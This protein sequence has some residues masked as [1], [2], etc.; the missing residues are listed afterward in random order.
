VTENG[1]VTT[2][3]RYDGAD[4][5][6]AV[7][8]A[9]TFGAGNTCTNGLGRSFTYD[10]L[11]RLGS[12]T[13]PESGVIQYTQYDGNGNLTGKTDARSVAASMTYDQLNRIR[14]KS[15]NDGVTP[16]VTYCYDGTVAGANQS[17]V[18][19]SVPNGKGRLTQVYSS[20][21][22]ATYPAFDGMGRVLLSSQQTP[23]GTG[24][25]LNFG[26]SAASPGYAYNLAGQLT[27]VT[28][29]SGRQVKY[30]YDAAGRTAHVKNPAASSYA[31]LSLFNANLGQYAYAAFGGIQQMNL[32]NSTSENTTWDPVRLQPTQIQVAPSL[33]TLNYY[34]CPNNGAS[35]STN[36]GNVLSQVIART[37]WS[38]TQNYTYTDGF[39]RLNSA[40]EW[41]TGSN[42]PSLNWSQTYQYDN[43]GNRAVSGYLPNASL[44]PQ[45]LSQYTGNRY[46]GSGAGYDAAG[47]LTAL[48]NQT[49]TYDAENR[50]TSSTQLGIGAIQ[51]AYD[52]DG[53]RVQK[54]FDTAATTYVYDA[55]GQLAAEYGTPTDTGTNYLNVDALGSTRVSNGSSLRNYDYFPFGEDIQQ[56][57]GGRNLSYPT[58]TY[59]TGTPDLQAMKFT[60]QLRDA[61]TGLDYFGARYFSGAQGR[62][63]SADPEGRGGKVPDPQSWN[64]YSYARNNPLL[65]T[66]PTG[67]TYQIC[68]KDDNGKDQCSSVSDE[69]F[70]QLQKNPGSGISLSNGDINAFVNGEWT[71]AGTYWQTDV[72]LPAGVGMALHA[73]GASADAE[74]K[75]FARDVAIG[76]GTGLVAGVVIG[77]AAEG[78][79]ALPRI[80]PFKDAD[81]IQRVSRA[82]TRIGQGAKMY[83][84][85]GIPFQNREGLLPGQAP[86][87]YT[88]YTV[89]PAAGGAGRGAERL[90]LGK[91][92]EVY[93][94]PNHYGSFVRIQ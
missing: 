7:C 63:T 86:G 83:S 61:E 47:N 80:L 71:K 35:C 94:T 24:S 44:T 22:T 21:S 59:P 65:Y 37:P 73:A 31:D 4:N 30:D 70:A 28:F 36:N 14:T 72:D 19:A 13:N 54:T 45:T 26:S 17:C 25:T 76:V 49:F 78:I 2:Y 60:G 11:R 85:D 6:T 74:I 51:Y 89:E 1:S 12:A 5:L 29:P 90:V 67:E 66:D 16:A 52:G 38:V 93:Y 27:E 20:A 53:R 84:R 39:N 92:G 58:G 50:L 48:T 88:E 33:L 41:V 23:S 40:Q 9:G 43:Y 69:Q 77:A 3:Y 56:G 42:P 18:S 87:Y 64:M 46:T 55:S 79:E 15:Y 81:L 32:G 68:V 91:G 82:L 10:W 57:V 34:Y 62:F 8:Q 75:K